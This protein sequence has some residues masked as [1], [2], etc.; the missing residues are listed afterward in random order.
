MLGIN[1]NFKFVDSLSYN[2]RHRDSFVPFMVD[3]DLF[4]VSFSRFRVSFVLG[5]NNSKYT[6]FVWLYIHE[7][8]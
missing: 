5:Q 8:V 1:F 6:K 3:D 4:G 7:L 2:L